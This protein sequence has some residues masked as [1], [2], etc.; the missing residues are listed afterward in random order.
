LD[1]APAPL[2]VWWRDDDAG[3]DDA[4]LGTLL[5]ISDR[6]AAPVALA[7]VPA[8]VEGGTVQRVRGHSL[9]TVVQHGW[10]HADH[11]RPGGRRIELGGEYTP[12]ALRHDL[13]RGAHRLQEAF[14]EA[15]LAVMVPP[16]NR[17]EPWAAELL[18]VLGYEA[19]STIAVTGRA[20]QNGPLP[21]IDVEVDCMRWDGGA[22]WRGLPEITHCVAAR[23]ATACSVPLGFM[24]HHRV[25]P[26]QAFADFTL[27]LSVLSRHPRVMLQGI[28]DL[29]P[30]AERLCRS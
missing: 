29:L 7:V 22:T 3:P 12:D 4:R 8:W 6:C 19:V 25:M 9:V 26:D 24:T 13:Q 17:I 23:A 14:D 18:P 20:T 15:Y 30:S 5:E 2:S 28:R 10:A 21:Q 16:W 11:A 1:E 27:L